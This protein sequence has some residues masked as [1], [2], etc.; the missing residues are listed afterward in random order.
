MGRPSDLARPPRCSTG[1]S[2]YKFNDMGD[3]IL[4]TNKIGQY[5]QLGFTD[6]STFQKGY[7]MWHDN[8]IGQRAEDGIC[9]EQLDIQ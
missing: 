8:V 9:F 7:F 2:N 3:N 5:M 1:N 4:I 6:V